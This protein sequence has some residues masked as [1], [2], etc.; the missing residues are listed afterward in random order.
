MWWMT[1]KGG[2]MRTVAVGLI[3]GTVVA[4]TAAVPAAASGGGGC[5]GPVTEGTGEQVAIRQ[6]CFEPTVLAAPLGAE[7]TFTNEDGF[8]H[9]VLG[10]NATWGS[11]ARL[12]DG[13]ARTYSF[14]EPGV[15]P[16]V[17]S[18]HPG[19]VGAVLIGDRDVAVPSLPDEAGGASV[20][21]QARRAGGDGPWKP[22]AVAVGALLV[23]VVLGTAGLRGRLRE[24]HRA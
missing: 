6:F 1:W 16:Y 17:C 13:K 18:W 10:A 11:F 24:D 22:L 8:P 7:V 5:G 21:A 19:M 2:T 9:N 15:Y 12:G 20:E 23:F 4:L 3:G 14:D